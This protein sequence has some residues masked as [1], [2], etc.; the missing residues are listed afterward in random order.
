MRGVDLNTFSFDWDLTFAA[1]LMHDDGTVYHRYGGRDHESADARL[2]M[3]A[4]TALLTDALGEDREYRESPRAKEGVQK[5]ALEE[6]PVFAERLKKNP[7]VSC[8]HCHM[9][10]EARRE[11]AQK[12]GRWTPDDRWLWPL[13]DKTGF[14]LAPD[15]PTEVVSVEKDSPAAKAGLAKG[16]LLVSVN[17]TRVRTEPDVQWFLHNTPPAGGRIEVAFA[18][19]GESRSATIELG[20]GWKAATPLEYSWRPAMWL[21]KPDPGFGGNDLGADEKKKLGIAPDGF[22]VRVDYLIDWG[23][24]AETGRSAR[25]AGVRKGDILVSVDGVADFRDHRHFQAWFRFTR[26]PGDKARLRLLRD[27]KP[28]ELEL[29]VLP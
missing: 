12:D 28:V 1:L 19:N 6:I 27:G 20:P 2:S 16:D 21:L 11:Q 15:R 25:N 3:K 7:N 23:E 5:Q 22:A 18:R 29:P 13:P 17:G 24:R 9:A 14:R 26:K 10:T 8:L 4:L